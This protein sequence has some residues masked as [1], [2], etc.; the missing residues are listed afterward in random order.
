MGK[1]IKLTRSSTVQWRRWRELD[2]QNVSGR[3]AWMVLSRFWSVPR[4]YTVLNKWRKKI[5]SSA[6]LGSRGKWLFNC[7]MCVCVLLFTNCKIRTQSHVSNHYQ[8][9]SFML[10]KHPINTLN[11]DWLSPLPFSALTWLGDRKGIWSRKNLVS[12]ICKGSSQEQ[13]KE[14]NWGELANLSSHGNWPLTWKC[15]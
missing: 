8:M 11:D 10:T 7:C 9:Q 12:L 15:W 5:Y 14:E 4:R 3:D 6:K 13:V 1:R 2:K